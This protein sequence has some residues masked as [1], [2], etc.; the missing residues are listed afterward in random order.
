M[1]VTED[2]AGKTG[3]CPKCGTAMKV[4]SAEEIQKFRVKTGMFERESGQAKPVGEGTRPGAKAMKG[5]RSKTKTGIPTRRSTKRLGKTADDDPD[6]K[7]RFR[8]APGGVPAAK[9]RKTA[10]MKKGARKGKTGKF[11]RG[12][13]TRSGSKRGS[14]RD[15]QAAAAPSGK[16]SAKYAMPRKKYWIPVL[17]VIGAGALIGIGY[18]IYYSSVSGY[19]KKLDRF[20]AYVKTTQA[21]RTEAEKYA[22]IYMTNPPLFKDFDNEDS[23]AR[24]MIERPWNNIQIFFERGGFSEFSEDYD[25][26]SYDALEEVKE[27]LVGEDM[28]GFLR[29][30]SSEMSRAT[31]EQR[32]IDAQKEKIYKKASSAREILQEVTKE[33]KRQF[34]FYAD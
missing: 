7:T 23:G 30:Y 16:I 31:P 2:M 6:E 20:N 29:T 33:L 22:N 4:P 27:L 12:A 19:V 1:Q 15:S 17:I 5:A 10:V 3:K 9:G 8:K 32:R 14:K 11:E 26:N 13:S 18:W 24:G 34:Y 28:K 21:F 25:Y